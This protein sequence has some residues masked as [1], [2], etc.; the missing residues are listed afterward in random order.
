MPKSYLK[1]FL[2]ACFV[3]LLALPVA[4]AQPPQYEII[5]LGVVG[6]SF[7]GG[8]TISENG[9]FA[10]GFTN[11][12]PFVWQSTGGTTGLPS[13]SGQPFSTPWGINNSGTMVGIGATTFFGSNAI[14][15][16]WQNGTATVLGLPTGEALGRA[17]AINNNG[18]IVGSVDGGSTEQAAM[19][20]LSGAGVV[21]TQTLGGGTLQT[22]YG[23]N[24]A[25]R[26]VGL[27]L[28]PNNAAVIH[29]FYLDPGDT[30]AHDIGALTALGHNS[31]IAFDVSSNG[32]ITGSSSINGGADGRA[33]L[34]S[35]T[36]GM[37]EIALP[38]GTSTA[39]GRGVNAD[40]WVVGTA[41]GTFAVPFLFDGTDTYSLQ[42]LIALGGS[43]WVLDMGTS[44]GA[45]AIADDGTIIGRGMFN[46]QLTAFAMIRSSAVPEPGSFSILGL[47]AISVV[48]R[49]RRD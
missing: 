17:Y 43:G 27:A 36:D 12:D 23:I 7:S 3:G 5:S 42:D 29:G 34:W 35:E 21:L 46:G 18:M 39:S 8:Q 19:F 49:R 38:T 25:G 2:L 45:F 10:G 40:G 9:Q 15:V 28:D 14:P 31:S 13:A 37:I 26:I 30:A 6:E 33:F 4:S 32:L 16:A 22:A 20:S 48:F 47:I 41:G 44:S 24:D 1:P 11:D